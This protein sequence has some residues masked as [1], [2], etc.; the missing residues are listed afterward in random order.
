M[1]RCFTVNY[2]RYIMRKN[3]FIC[4]VLIF[5]CSL[6]SVF[7]DGKTDYSDKANWAYFSDGEDKKADLFIIAPTV[8]MGKAGNTNM[9]FSDEKR[10]ANFLGAL[11]MERGIFDGTCRLYSPYY[12]QMTMKVYSSSPE[13]KETAFN[14]AYE[15]VRSAFMYYM[16]NENSGRPFI[17]AGFSQGAEMCFALMKE[18]FADN[19]YED[20]FIETYAMGWCFTADDRARYPQLVPASGQY[21]TGTI[22]CFDAESE[23]T[24]STMIIPAGAKTFSINPLNWKTDSTP[25]DRNMNS[26]ACFTDYHARIVKEQKAL[27]GAYIDPVR[28]SLKVT[29]VTPEEYPAGIA[30]LGAGSYHIYDYQFFF[31]NLQQNVGQRTDAFL[32]KK[33]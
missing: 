26:G 25:A 3:R 10:M 1:L 14:T 22:V 4:I 12:H 33:R 8:D 24:D 7:P 11:N 32:Q 9:S 15:D 31:R 6:F 29:D 5:S 20:R 13:E 16:K 30:V 19:Q 21:D 2:R 28:G 23:K 27:C 18:F 17:L